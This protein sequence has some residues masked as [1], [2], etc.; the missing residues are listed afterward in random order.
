MFNV[1]VHFAYS[2]AFPAPELRAFVCYLLYKRR[3][4]TAA[5]VTSTVQVT[6]P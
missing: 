4:H 1:S 2:L 3:I 6:R 5:R